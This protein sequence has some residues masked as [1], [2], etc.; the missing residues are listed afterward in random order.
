MVFFR[1]Q[2]S[3]AIDDI[4]FNVTS[5]PIPAALPLFATALAGLGVFGWR[6][7]KAGTA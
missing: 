1:L 3:G 4:K 5:M 7:R 2:G 6:K